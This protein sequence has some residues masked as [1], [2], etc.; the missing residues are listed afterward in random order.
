MLAETTDGALI[1]LTVEAHTAVVGVQ[2]P[3]VTAWIARVL[4]RR[5]VIAT[6]ETS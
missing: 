4:S 1:G 6:R 3:G 2:A 5:P